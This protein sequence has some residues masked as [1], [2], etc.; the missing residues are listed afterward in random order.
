MGGWTH[1]GAALVHHLP[2]DPSEGLDRQP[3]WVS[4]ANQ[5]RA[6]RQTAGTDTAGTTSP[7]APAA[8]LPPSLARMWPRKGSSESVR[9]PQI[10]CS[11]PQPCWPHRVPTCLPSHC[12]H[13]QPCLKDTGEKGEGGEEGETPL[14][15]HQLKLLA[16]DAFTSRLQAAPTV[17]CKTYMQH[18]LAYDGIFLSLSP[19]HQ[20]AKPL[21]GPNTC[22]ATGARSRQTG[23]W[24]DWILSLFCIR[25]E[26]QAFAWGKEAA[27]RGAPG[28]RGEGAKTSG[29]C[30]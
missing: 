9:L 15:F 1:C 7:A 27:C 10:Q 20:I 17:G 21:P 6:T 2:P 14:M 18:A 23:F 19:A 8:K 12:P 5:H 29:F 22:P 4:A 28:E 16:Q 30:Y 13:P 25:P 3:V 24:Q 11:F 26:Q